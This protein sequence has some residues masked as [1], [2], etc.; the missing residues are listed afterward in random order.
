MMGFFILLIYLY[1]MD[2]KLNKFYDYIVGNLIRSTK[3]WKVDNHLGG[4]LVGLNFPMYCDDSLEFFYL[5]DD[6]EEWLDRGWITGGDDIRY[7]MIR[8]G[9]TDSECREVMDIY[10]KKLATLILSKYGG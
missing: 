4:D 2:D 7:L 10:G 9:L 5:T 3:V 6:I 8:Y 1:G